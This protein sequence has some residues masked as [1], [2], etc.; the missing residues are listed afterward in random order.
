M[1]KL[2]FVLCFVAAIS[3][4]L[5][6]GVFLFTQE[7]TVQWMVSMVLVNGFTFACGVFVVK[8]HDG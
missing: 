3:L 2:G 1:K 5:C 4:L 7:P 8:M 6:F